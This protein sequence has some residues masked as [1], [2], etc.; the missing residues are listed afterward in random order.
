MLEL[1]STNLSALRSVQLVFVGMLP[2][3]APQF[4]GGSAHSCLTSFTGSH[5]HLVTAT[6]AGNVPL[7]FVT[8]RRIECSGKP[9]NQK[10]L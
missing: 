9:Q 1:V 10:P 7:L 8:I 6:K 4:S 3:T 5:L 2:H